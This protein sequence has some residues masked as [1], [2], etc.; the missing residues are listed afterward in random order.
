MMAMAISLITQVVYTMKSLLQ[1]SGIALVYLLMMPMISCAMVENPSEDSLS[2]DKSIRIGHLPNGFTYYL[3]PTNDTDKISLRFYV[4][5]GNYN[6]RLSENQFAHLVEHIGGNEVY[7]KANSEND[8]DFMKLATYTNANTASTYTVY[9]S[10]FPGS[11][12]KTLRVRLEGYANISRLKAEDSIVLQESRCVRQELFNRAKGLALNR[13][14]DEFVYEAAIFFDTDGDT[15]YTDW[16]TTYDM[17]G[18]SV[19]SVREFYRRWYRPDRMGLIITGNIVDMDRME[20][21]LIALYGKIPKT[22]AEGDYFDIRQFYLSLSPRFK[23]VERMEVNRFT[24]WDDEDSE[25]S[26]FFRVKKFYA[27]LNS[28]E[29]WLNQQLYK[30]MYIMIDNRLRANS[31]AVVPLWTDVEK[32]QFLRASYIVEMENKSG[33]ER[34]NI[35]LVTSILQQLQKDGFTQHEWDKQKQVMLNRITTKDTR[36]T[37]Y[38]EDQLE[39]HF[40]YGEILPLQKKEVTK[41]W[42]DNLSLKD[43]NSYFQDNFSVM[44]EDIYIT[45][46]AGHPA[47]SYTEK[48]VRGWIKEAIKAPDGLKEIADIS[49][50]TPVDNK[51]AALMSEKEVERLK[52]VSY[53]KIGIDPDTG[54][55]IIQLKNGVKLLLDIKGTSENNAEMISINGNSPR[56]ASFFPKADYY[57]AISAP[58]IVKLSGAGNFNRKTIRSK[59][60]K[61]FRPN[62]EPV[63]LHIQHNTS[64]VST[65]TSLE[66]LEKY[67]QLVYLYF[68]APR[69]DSSAFT[70]WIDQSRQRYFSDTF[71]VVIPMDVDMKNAIANFLDVSAFKAPTNEMSTALF[72]QAHDVVYRQALE[73]YRA[74]FGNASDFTFIVQGKYE[75]ERILPLLQKYLGNLPTIDHISFSRDEPFNKTDVELPQGPVYHTFYADK[76]KT[77]YKLYT[78]PY[79]LFYAFA[80]PKD[81]WKD[82]MILNLINSYLLPKV[83]F[84]LRYIKGGSFYNAFTEG[85]YIEK[86]ALY[87]LAVYVDALDDEL[88]WIR[89]EC[90]AMIADIKDHGLN[91]KAI[92]RVLKDPLFGGYYLSVPALEKKIMQYASLLTSKDIK[93]VA[94]KYFTEDNQYEFVF[95]ER[96][97]DVEA[98]K[99]N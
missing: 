63:Q 12:A 6:E 77:A 41:R 83:R 50:L 54:L 40:V 35:E 16:L 58:E 43:I 59:L 8:V 74:I 33:E 75:K 95:R 15:P 57:A 96:K 67:L 9:H 73:C 90:K 56:G 42:I 34:E 1:L 71:H 37:E 51:N 64:T 97:K 32:S 82:R 25:T 18:V 92:E 38:W 47:L 23:A 13:A 4:K 28:K 76:M 79:V 53:R 69:E 3:K 30:A 81:A 39:K 19:P 24:G 93:K 86:D 80:I 7:Q 52:E 87:S 99:K 72:Y 61:V 98:P 70:Q 26:L 44:P 5:V 14:F 10:T 21:Q 36:S 45:A 84:E 2:I 68:T 49:S 31:K 11:D 91:K 20:Q 88:E 85:R 29:K 66:D 89:S 46:S 94:V 27:L 48:Q 17:G 65:R 60:D 78:T 62:A 22:T 55:E